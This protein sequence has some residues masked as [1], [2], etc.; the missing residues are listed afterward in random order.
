MVSSSTLCE[1]GSINDTLNFNFVYAEV[2]VYCVVYV[3]D[4]IRV[5]VMSKTLNKLASSTWGATPLK[6]L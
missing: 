2:S 4:A 1:N 3:Y 6:R 5:D